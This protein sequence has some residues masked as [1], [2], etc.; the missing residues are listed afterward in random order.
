[1]SQIVL[2]FARKSLCGPAA[3]VLAYILTQSHKLTNL[4]LC[5]TGI[6]AQGAEAIGK[7]LEANSTFTNLNLYGNTIGVYRG[8]C[9]HPV[10]N[11]T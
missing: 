8:R 5:Y 2:T 1:M 4:R 3:H 9:H 7:A 10:C 6:G 11:E